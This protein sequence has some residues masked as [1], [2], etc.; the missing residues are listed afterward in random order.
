MAR[1]AVALAKVSRPRLSG[2]VARERLFRALDD[3][4]RHPVVWVVGPPGAGKT[5]LVATYLE[6]RRLR[7]IWYQ[8]DDGDADPASFF[9]YLAQAEAAAGSNERTPLPLLRPEYLRDLS[10]FTRRFFRELFGRLPREAAL[11]LDNYQDVTITSAF[12][13]VVRDALAE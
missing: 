9:Y 8:V 7:A 3:Q 4:R 12:H 5:T 2:V 6:A 1:Q 10:G 11:V 13:D